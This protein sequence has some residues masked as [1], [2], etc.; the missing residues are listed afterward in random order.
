MNLCSVAGMLRVGYTEG[1][2]PPMGN[3]KPTG[4]VGEISSIFIYRPQSL[5][6]RQRVVLLTYLHFSVGE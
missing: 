2:H 6:Q 1:C 4:T 5:Y 3:G